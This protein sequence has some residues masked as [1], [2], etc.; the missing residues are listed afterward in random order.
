MGELQEEDPPLEALRVWASLR[1]LKTPNKHAAEQK[2]KGGK[3]EKAAY[4]AER[5]RRDDFVTLVR[6]IIVQGT[7]E[8]G[9]TWMELQ[10]AAEG[11][12]SLTAYRDSAGA[13]AMVLFDEVLEKLKKKGRDAFVIED[14][15]ST[16]ERR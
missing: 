13:T 5:K 15:A 7:V 1:Q 16:S 6:R 8:T 14:A 4:R 9:T 12:R 11:D 2:P 3:E 10:A